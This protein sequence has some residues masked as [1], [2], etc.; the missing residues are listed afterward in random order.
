MGSGARLLLDGIDV[1]ARESALIAI[2]RCRVD[3]A[4]RRPEIAGMRLCY[5]QRWCETCGFHRRNIFPAEIVLW[6]CEDGCGCLR[7]RDGSLPVACRGICIESR[8][9][10]SGAVAGARG[11]RTGDQIA[12]VRI[13]MLAREDCGARQRLLGIGATESAS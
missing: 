8:L 3:D 11:Q 10:K 7:V 5:R 12:T 13:V 6:F 9:T 1:A 4:V 2:D